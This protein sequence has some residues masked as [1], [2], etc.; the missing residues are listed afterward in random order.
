MRIRIVVADDHNLVREG[1]TAL[2]AREPSF[3]MV[4]QAEDGH[5]AVRRVRELLPDVLLTDLNMP[6]LN[7]IETIRHV[8]ADHPHVKALCVSMH[9][10][11]RMV[12]EVID[13]G[14][15]GYVLKDAGFDELNQAIHKVMAGHVYLSP[16]LVSIVVQAA[17]HRRAEPGG[18]HAHGLTPRERE[19]VQLL[20]EGHSTARI[21]QRLNVSVKTVASHRENILRKLSIHSIAELTRYAI[22]EGL[23]SLE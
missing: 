22:R 4:G 5:D 21:A 12:M 7:G 9:N 2:L 17:R 18:P 6:G 11:S 8:R 3:E 14:A 10:D 1:L 20:S 15:A 13:A 23:S 16:E 19:M